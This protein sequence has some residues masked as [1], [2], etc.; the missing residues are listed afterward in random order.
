MDLSEQMRSLVEYDGWAN[1]RIWTC[2]DGL[3]DAQFTS[4]PLT[5][6]RSIAETLAHA[7]G[8]RVWWLSRWK[9]HDFVMPDISTLDC[10]RAAYGTV[11]TE[12]AEFAGGVD[13]EGWSTT[14][15]AF[16]P[17]QPLSAILA[18]VMLHGVQHRA[19]L[20]AMLSAVGRSPGDLDYIFFLRERA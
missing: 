8:T 1:E 15:D 10:L 9:G 18:Q 4:A 5:R 12:L 13:A 7:L 14:F 19:E 2:V 6:V 16:G 17:K 3:D 11:H 20:A